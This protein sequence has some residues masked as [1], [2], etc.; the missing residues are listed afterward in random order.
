MCVPFGHLQR[1]VSSK[2]LDEF[3][4][5]ARFEHFRDA[6]ILQR[7]KMVGLRHG[8]RVTHRPPHLEHVFC[9]IES[10]AG[11]EGCGKDELVGIA[12]VFFQPAK[13]FQNIVRKGDGPAVMVF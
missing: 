8:E 1:V 5:H 4:R 12:T 2:V 11:P 3:R 13:I 6:R 7:V 9:C 10:F